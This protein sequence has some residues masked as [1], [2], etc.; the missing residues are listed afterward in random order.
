MT[1]D[2]LK[3]KVPLT[4]TRIVRIARGSGAFIEEV[5]ILIEE[6]KKMKVIVEKF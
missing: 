3:S 2:E 5:E 4:Q 1:Q 6:H